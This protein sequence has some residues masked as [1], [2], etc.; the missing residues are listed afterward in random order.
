MKKIICVVLCIIVVF[1]GFK[2]WQVSK[3]W[4]TWKLTSVTCLGITIDRSD[5]E[6]Y[7]NLMKKIGVDSDVN[8]TIVEFTA[9]P[10]SVDV[11][12]G[13]KTIIADY[14]DVDLDNNIIKVAVEDKVLEFK[15]EDGKM[16][17]EGKVA[18]F[19]FEK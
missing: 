6:S 2:T 12:I 19:I 14:V 11:N 3:Y 16:V 9:K 18:T 7:D 10:A 17:L 4:G 15:L 8:N 1:V 5:V 13:D